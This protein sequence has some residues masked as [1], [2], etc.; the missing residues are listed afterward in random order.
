MIT[1]K[2]EVGRTYCTRDGRMVLIKGRS[3]WRT[4]YIY[5][6]YIEGNRKQYSWGEDGR[7]WGQRLGDCDIIAEWGKEQP[8]EESDPEPV[9]TLRDEFAMAALPSFV[10]SIDCS[11]DDEA[12]NAYK[13]ADAML[14]A[15]QS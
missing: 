2:L 1:L 9:K 12:K 8:K 11:F 6:G 10:V 5:D 7:E 13:A 15:R 14:K 3:L 4:N